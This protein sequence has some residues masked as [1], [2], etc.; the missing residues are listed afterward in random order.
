MANSLED[1]KRKAPQNGIRAP[2]TKNA[3]QGSDFWNTTRYAINAIQQHLNFSE[4]V[5]LED[6]L[7][8]LM[9]IHFHDFGAARK[10]KSWTFTCLCSESNYVLLKN[11]A[12]IA[13]HSPRNDNHATHHNSSTRTIVRK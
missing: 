5:N 11:M 12:K 13:T 9:Y 4:L 8:K 10:I 7:I 2:D 1:L 6:C 3:A